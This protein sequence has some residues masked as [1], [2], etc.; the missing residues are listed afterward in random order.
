MLMQ[1]LDSC[2]FPRPCA[3][4]RDDFSSLLRVD[5]DLGEFCNIGGLDQLS[6][7]L[8]MRGSRKEVLP[9]GHLK[10]GENIVLSQAGRRLSPR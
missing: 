2:C 9:I 6:D 10:R 1:L 3:S 4:V 7:G 8:K 5:D